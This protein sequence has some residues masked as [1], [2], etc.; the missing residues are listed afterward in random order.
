MKTYE[1]FTGDELRIAEKIL[2]RRYQLLVHSCI[3]YHLDQNV[4][5]D[6]T[7][8][9]WSNE[10]VQLQKLY[11][12][13][14]EQVSLHEYFSDWDGSTGAFLPITQPWVIKIAYQ[15]LDIKNEKPEQEI[16]KKKKRLF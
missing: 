15:L 4:V 2:Q 11:P 8:N 14:A 7:W 13:I 3:Y 1:L 12:K 6:T 5:S 16:G 9:K 10:L